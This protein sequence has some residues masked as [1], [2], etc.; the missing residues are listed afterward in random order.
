MLSSQTKDEVNAAAMG[1]LKKH[2]LTVSNILK[3]DDKKLE[4]LIYPVG[5]YKVRSTGGSSACRFY[6]VRPTGGSS[7]CEACP[8]AS[9]FVDVIIGPSRSSSPSERIVKKVCSPFPAIFTIVVLLRTMLCYVYAHVCPILT[10]YLQLHL[11]QNRRCVLA[12]WCNSENQ[13]HQG[14]Y[15]SAR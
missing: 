14:Y 10:G 3:T 4:E 15:S 11:W 13:S 6:K 7:A 8:S 5:F 9:A 1:R 12:T 2:G